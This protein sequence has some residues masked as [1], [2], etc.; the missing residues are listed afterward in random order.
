MK[1]IYY[2][3]ARRLGYRSF[4]ATEGSDVVELKRMLQTTGYWRKDADRVPEGPDFDVDRALMRTDPDRFFE[5]VQKFREVMKRLME[6]YGKYDDETVQAVD[7]F[8]EDHGLDHSG[9]PPGLVDAALVEAL[10]E[11]YYSANL[12]MA[13]KR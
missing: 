2:T 9:H 1:R 4:S 10:R 3:T 11:A 12:E 8:R 13:E 5:E 6:S 7:R